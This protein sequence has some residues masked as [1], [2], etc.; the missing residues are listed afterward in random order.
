[1]HNRA[2][3][4]DCFPASVPSQA[5]CCLASPGW[6]SSFGSVPALSSPSANHKQ[7][8]ALDGQ[9]LELQPTRKVKCLSVRVCD[10]SRL[11]KLTYPPTLESRHPRSITGQLAINRL[12]AHCISSLHSINSA[13]AR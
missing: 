12:S 7:R 6:R 1:M 13:V 4:T 10:F 8:R 9:L 5:P 3:S 2:P 11:T